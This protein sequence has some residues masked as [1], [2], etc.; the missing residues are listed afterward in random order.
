[1]QANFASQK[2]KQK[3]R[4][5]HDKAR[6]QFQYYLFIN[7]IILFLLKFYTQQVKMVFLQEGGNKGADQA[8]RMR[9]LIC[10]FVF[11]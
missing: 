10:G 7:Q 1:M 9:K 2:Q 4:F 5:S 11:R 8:A 6:L 3:K